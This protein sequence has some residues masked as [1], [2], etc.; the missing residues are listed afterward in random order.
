MERRRKDAPQRFRRT[1][2]GDEQSYSR[3]RPPF[4]STRPLEDEA[5]ASSEPLQRLDFPLG[6]RPPSSPPRDYD[7][8]PTPPDTP[9]PSAF[10]DMPPLSDCS[11]PPTPADALALESEVAKSISLLKE[12]LSASSSP[13]MDQKTRQRLAPE[14]KVRR[15]VA[16]ALHNE[17]NDNDSSSEASPDQQ[18]SF[19]PENMRKKKAR[20]L[21]SVPIQLPFSGKDDEGSSSPASTDRQQSVDEDELRGGP[22]SVSSACSSMVEGTMIFA[23]AN[24]DLQCDFS[25]HIDDD[26]TVELD[27]L[28]HEGSSSFSLTGETRDEDFREAL[29][30]DGGDY[31]LIADEL[32][33]ALSEHVDITRQTVEQKMQE[34]LTSWG[35]ETSP[36]VQAPSSDIFCSANEVT[37]PNGVDPLSPTSAESDT[38]ALD[39]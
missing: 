15:Q 5:P 32:A 10:D 28:E 30:Q 31:Y 13:L 34:S 7:K 14:A 39:D 29:E 25:D 33:K 38:E 18:P 22:A 35:S 11:T 17:D 9:K 36:Q 19:L 24:P 26:S 37:K 16:R 12:S 8:L 21:Q 2:S 27:F 1:L 23:S 3:N 4:A 6:D 20:N